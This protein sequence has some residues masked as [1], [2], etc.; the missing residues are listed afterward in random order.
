MVS[1]PPVLVLIICLLII[2]LFAFLSC[3][4]I[5]DCS[6]LNVETMLACL[7]IWGCGMG[8][9][10]RG[11]GGGSLWWLSIG[12]IAESVGLSFLSVAGFSGEDVPVSCLWRIDFLDPRAL[13]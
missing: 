13:H 7:R 3:P 1:A 4:G 12:Y 11:G 2:L 6:S 10:H 5:Y 8:T 9:W